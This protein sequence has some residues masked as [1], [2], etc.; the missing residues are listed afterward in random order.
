MSEKEA[1]KIPAGF[2]NWMERDRVDRIEVAITPCR[3]GIVPHL[4]VVGGIVKWGNFPLYTHVTGE[5][6]LVGGY[7][8]QCR[9]EEVIQELVAHANKHL[10]PGTRYE[11]RKHLPENYGRTHT[12]SWYACETMDDIE[13][14]VSPNRP[15]YQVAIGM[16]LMARR[17]AGEP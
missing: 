15:E 12:I 7:T 16:T 13:P 4:A 1:M 9:E 2:V 17:I 8:V 6:C 3:S 5:P 11:I 10:P 14:W